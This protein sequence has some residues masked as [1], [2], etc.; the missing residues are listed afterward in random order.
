MGRVDGGLCTW[1][2]GC[3]EK[4]K[5]WSTSGSAQPGASLCPE[6]QGRGNGHPTHGCP[7]V[8]RMR[9]GRP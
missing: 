4:L 1:Y 3:D 6:R 9:L 8:L 5:D 2:W 7:R